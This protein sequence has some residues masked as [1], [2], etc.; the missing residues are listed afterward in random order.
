MSR[1]KGYSLWQIRLH[2]I[3]VGLIALQFLL[4][5]PMTAAWDAL[6]E[7]RDPG[8]D[9]LVAAHVFGGLAVLALALWRLALRAA[10]GVPPPP[11]NEGEAARRLGVFVHGSLYALMVL[12]PATGALAWFGGVEVSALGHSV[13]RVLLLGLVAVHVAAALA[14]HFVRGTGVIDRMRR[15]EEP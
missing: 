11:E 2:W 9:P 5:E 6:R 1:P 4:H 8:F 14:L 10:R 12:M 15:P 7:G 13:L 3:V